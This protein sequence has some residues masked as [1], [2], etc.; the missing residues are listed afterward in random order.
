V[1]STTVGVFLWL[2]ASVV[3]GQNAAQGPQERLGQQAGGQVLTSPTVLESTPTQVAQRLR[4][5]DEGPPPGSERIPSTPPS[6]VEDRLIFEPV[7]DRW[8]IGY[9]RNI[10]DPYNQNILKGDYP[11]PGTQNLFFVFTGISDTLAEVRSLP[12]PSGVSAENADSFGFFGDNRQVIFRENLLLRFELYRGD[13]A[14]KP[15]DFLLTIT[16][17]LNFNYVNLEERGGVNID[18]RQGTNRARGDAALQEGSFEYHIANLSDRYDSISIKLGIQPFVSDFRGFIFNDTNLG[19]RLFGN[20]GNNRYQYNLVFFDMLEKETNS[21][22]N[23]FDRR[24]QRIVIANLYWQDLFVLGYTTQ[25]NLHYVHDKATFQFD[26]N[27]FLVRPD[28]VGVF[29]PHELNVVYLGW[30]SSGHIG[31]LNVTHALYQA[32]GTDTRNP[33]AGRRVTVNAQMAALELSID[34]DWLRPVVSVTYASGDRNPTNGKAQGFDSIFDKP[35]FA[36]GDF[37]FWNRQGI[38]LLNVGLVQGGSFLPDLRSSKI[39]GQPNFVNPGLVRLHA[40]LEAEVTPKL[41]ALF[42]GSYLRFATVQPLQ[43]FLQ[44]PKIGHDIGF[45]FSLGLLYRPLLN[46]NIILTGGV[47]AFIPGNGFKDA[48]THETLFQGFLNVRLLY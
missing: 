8:R 18:V 11:I 12:I 45:D 38:R 27:N 29:T 30:T 35:N 44:Q 21:E 37:S 33:L 23:T 2:F 13:T 25:F 47:A 39:Q 48:L 20:L 17:A 26:R 43:H 32:V 36:G 34:Y 40:G 28:A 6:E 22:L 41:R 7:R 24:D 19:A 42:N 14:F 4:R 3:W 5:F 31:I 9:K 15:P 16:P 1:K 10:W 46:N